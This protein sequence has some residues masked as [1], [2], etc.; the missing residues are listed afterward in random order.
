MC[1]VVVFVNVKHRPYP[2]VLD[3]YLAFL[4]ASVSKG[5]DQPLVLRWSL[6]FFLLFGD[7]MFVAL[8]NL[9]HRKVASVVYI[10]IFQRSRFVCVFFWHSIRP[11]QDKE[12]LASKSSGTKE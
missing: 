3:G 4:C 7:L 6:F 11:E 1:K 5:F 10:I 9:R 2:H 12:T 8:Q